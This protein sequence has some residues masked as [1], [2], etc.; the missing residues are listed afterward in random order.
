MTTIIE[1]RPTIVERRLIKE[2]DILSKQMPT[3]ELY[4]LDECEDNDCDCKPRY[5]NIHIEI[6]TPNLNRLTMTLSQD[7]PFKPP[8]FLKIN[9]RDYRYNLKHMPKR[10]EYLYNH[11]DDMYYEEFAKSTRQPS[12]LC[13]TCLCCKSI[14]CSDNWSPAIMFHNILKEVEEHNLLKRQ[15]MYKFA[16]KNLFDKLHL[17]LELLRSV[18]KYLA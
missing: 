13:C 7:Y 15:I 14:L 11:P 1:R 3:Y 8:R 9:G 18:Y 12:C 4:I 17:P 16:L 6:V 10:V 5:K 2:I